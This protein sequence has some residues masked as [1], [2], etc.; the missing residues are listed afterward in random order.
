MA[1]K[2]Q[3]AAK[4]EKMDKETND[5]IKKPVEEVKESKDKI[6]EPEKKQDKKQD[7]KGKGK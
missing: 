6:K 2:K 3:K 5:K 7:K 4:R 1:T